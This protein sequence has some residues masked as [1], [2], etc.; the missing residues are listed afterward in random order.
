MTSQQRRH[1][2]CPDV[3]RR[4]RAAIHGGD[5]IS[6]QGHDSSAVDRRYPIGCPIAALLQRR[7]DERSSTGTGSSC[8]EHH[9]TPGDDDVAR[10][11][12]MKIGEMTAVHRRR[13]RT[14]FT[15]D[16]V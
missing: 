15:N 11:T 9:V 16:Q 6:E 4:R 7:D 5:V 10:Q 2:N 1:D 12:E 14:A 3:S 13:R 8:S